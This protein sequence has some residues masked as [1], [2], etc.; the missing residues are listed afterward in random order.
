MDPDSIFIIVTS[1]L[2]SAFFS[3]MEIAFVASNKLH[4][5][6]MKK[7]GE[8]N[9]RILSPFLES[10]SR[11]IA[12]MLVGNNIALVVYGIEMAQ[13]LEPFIRNYTHSAVIVL[14]LQTIF[15][16][17]VVLVTA[18]FIPKVLFSI[19]ANRFIRLFALPAWACYYALY[20]VVSLVVGLSNL[21]LKY[22]L[23]APQMDEKPVFERVDLEEYL[24]EHRADPS[25]IDQ[26]ETEIQIFKNA[27]DFSKVKARECMVPRNEI[28]AMELSEDI[29]VLRAKFVETGF[30]K[31][32]IYRENIDQIIGY[33]HSYELFK[34]PED[35]KSI[36]LPIAMLPETMAA[37]DILN[38]FLKERKSI[39]LV[40]DEFGGTSGLVT[41][42]D[43]VE[44]IF[45]EIQDE[46]DSEALVERQVSPHEFVFSGRHEIDYL[47]EK[48]Q[49]GL[50]ASDDYETL[51]GL[52]VH[53]CEDIPS[54]KDRI[55]MDNFTFL[56]L[57]VDQTRIEKVKLFRAL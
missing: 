11:F 50:P 37:N 42:E 27:L 4:L 38:L 7:R 12:T 15:S 17:A 19:N 8:F 26:Q 41:V 14:C 48:Y 52:I 39:A 16:T 22:V 44:E 6:L 5:E 56:I 40:V 10:P 18:E 20:F 2:C 53:Y 43:I 25:E 13:I 28:V 33:T 49:L 57:E 35:I 45:G 34:S 1:L 47:N 3:G 51:S 36:L 21:I 32:V 23:R 55:R 30:S 54:Y 46:H 29:Q 9:A 31:I 24:N